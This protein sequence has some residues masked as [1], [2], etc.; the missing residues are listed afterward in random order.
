MAALYTCQSVLQALN[1]ITGGRVV[2][3]WRDICSCGNAHVVMKSSNIPGKSVMEI[4]GLVFGNPEAP[5]RRAAVAMTLTESAIEL[6]SALEIDLII[7]HHPVA[8]AANSGGVP[9]IEYLP[10]YGLSVI[11]LHEAFHGLHAGITWLHGHTVQ[12]TERAYGGIPGNVVHIG[13]ALEEVKTAGDI[14]E[15]LNRYMDRHV[16]STLLS[17]ERE[18]WS[19]GG[20]NEPTIA[21]PPHILVGDAHSPVRH[22]VHFFPHTGFSVEHLHQILRDHPETDTLIASI[23]RVRAH[24]PLAEAARRLGLT[25]IVG[26]PHT[27]EIFENGLPLAY[28]LRELLPGL[29]LHIFRERMISF[30]LDQAGHDEIRQY[31]MQMAEQY[32]VPQEAKRTRA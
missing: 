16:E 17:F 29:E 1:V 32:L 30:P 22:V 10:L 18:F 21:N 2:M 14:V 8:D 3:D 12:Y 31:G 28:A 13:I 6:A 7:V 20:A 25:F 4:P 19:A 24:H 11:E 26:N 9:F 15:R 27:V 23:S 5:V